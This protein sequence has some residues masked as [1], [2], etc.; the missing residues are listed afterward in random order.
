MHADVV[1]HSVPNTAMNSTALEQGRTQEGR[2]FYP[3]QGRWKV[4]FSSSLHVL[5]VH[6]G[7]FGGRGAF[8]CADTLPPPPHLHG[9]PH[10]AP[11]GF[12]RGCAAAPWRAPSHNS[13]HSCARKE[14]DFLRDEQSVFVTSCVCFSYP[15]RSR[16]NHALVGSDK[17][18]KHDEL[19][20]RRRL[21]R[22][23]LRQCRFCR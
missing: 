23:D 12:L 5:G 9:T 11:P 16:R 22:V 18:S 8:Q 2:I 7:D 4:V 1:N 6:Q 19:R 15:D 17:H 21:R 20:A 13:E 3:L 10:Q 14:P